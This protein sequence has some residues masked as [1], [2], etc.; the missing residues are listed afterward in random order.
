MSVED[1]K[2]VVLKHITIVAPGDSPNTDGIHIARTKDIQVMDCN[3]KTGDDCM[4][5][6]TGTENLYASKITCGPGHGINVGSLGDKNSEARVSN[7]TI[8]KAHLIGTTNGARIKSWQGGKGYAKD[9]TFE[10][11]IMTRSRIQ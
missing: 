9:I 6:E 3:I 10:D 8:N 4:S 2:D 1:C 11:I 7:I 5:I